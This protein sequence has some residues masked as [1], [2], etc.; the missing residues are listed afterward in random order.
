MDIP[1]GIVILR[2]AHTPYNWLR[3]DPE[4]S[5]TLKDSATDADSATRFFAQLLPQ[6]GFFAIRT[7]NAD[8]SLG[9]WLSRINCD[10]DVDYLQAAKSAID[11]Y[12]TFQYHEVQPTGKLFAVSLPL[13]TKKFWRRDDED[14]CIKPD[15]DIDW[16][17]ADPWS[18][19]PSLFSYQNVR[20]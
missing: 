4:D 19:K 3:L 11:V 5:Y 8:N 16:E 20:L 9:K 15:A 13:D 2:S 18:Y 10:N 14:N 17:A 6:D 7:I 12:C 1:S